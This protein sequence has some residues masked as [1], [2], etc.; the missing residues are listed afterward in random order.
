LPSGTKPISFFHSIVKNLERLSNTDKKLIVGS[1]FNVNLF[2]RSS[3]LNDLQ[4]WS[5]KAG[6][7]QLV[8]S[9]TWRRIVS[10]TVLT[11]AI[12]HV[13]TIDICK[14][15]L[16][17]SISDH[18]MIIVEKVFTPSERKKIVIRDWCGY[19]EEKFVT[20]LSQKMLN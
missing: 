3:N 8:K 5:I 12:D 18:D 10:G 1:D 7:H 15:K 20:Q 9:N 19:T 2:K 4:K 16:I 11:S 14:I 17:P 13:Y 6:L